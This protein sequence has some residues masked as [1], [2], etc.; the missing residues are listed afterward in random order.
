MEKRSEKFKAIA[1][2]A[3]SLFWKHGIRRVS[4]EEICEVAGVSK[5]TCYKYFSN[6]TA[7]AKYLIEDLFETQVNTYKEIY[8]SDISYE[9]K[10]K[11]IIDLKMSNA[12]EMSQELLDDIYKYQDEELA[13]TIEDIKKRM[14][15]IYL[16]DI[17]NEQKKGEIR[18][19][20]KPEF[21]LYF[22]NNLTE[23]LTDQQ[24]VRLYSNPEQMIIEVMSFFF[25]GIMPRKNRK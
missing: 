4:I 16:D 6:K 10:V 15:G 20:I 25:Y 19:D 5:M 12:H 3:K 24:L 13:E 2:A 1:S 7:I 9:E 11:K 8:N 18:S 17:R 23:M 21:M 22:L 14:I